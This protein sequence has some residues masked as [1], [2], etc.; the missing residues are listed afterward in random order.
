MSKFPCY[1]FPCV[2]DPN[3]F[4]PDAESC[5]PEEIA[6]HR[7]ACQTYGKPE[8]QPNKG[9]YSEYNE[10]GDMVLHVTRTSW[11][12]GTN[13]IQSCDNCR[14]PAFGEPLMVCHE[15]HEQEFCEVCW[16]E[17][18]KKHDQEIP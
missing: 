4:L 7:L 9:C 3:D 12:I 10:Q 17:H 18:E 5:S 2:D 6:A 15:C 16:P 1:G 11:G 8:H 14:E 13:L